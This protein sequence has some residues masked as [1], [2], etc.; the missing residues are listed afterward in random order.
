MI[1]N[2]KRMIDESIS[3]INE[4]TN[5]N[6]TAEVQNSDIFQTT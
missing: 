6:K 5:Y 4:N 2:E 1:N 3:S